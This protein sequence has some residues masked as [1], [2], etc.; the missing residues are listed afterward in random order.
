MNKP[1]TDIMADLETWGTEPGS[2]IAAIG[3]CVVGEPDLTFY[4][5]ITLQSCLDA[6]LRVSGSTVEWWLRQAPEAQAALLVDQ[7]DLESALY[8][9]SAW[10]HDRQ[11][12]RGA[13]LWGN[14]ANFDPV[15]LESAYRAVGQAIPWKFY[16]VACYRTMKGLVSFKA[17]KPTVA[18][19]ALYD[20]LAQAE[21]LV[22]IRRAIS[23]DLNEKANFDAT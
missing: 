11:L 20:A 17:P 8:Q 2:A 10:Y 4:T 1:T 5:T 16:E 19:H 12:G 7:V 22:A 9:F 13:R 23:V 6:G 15:L 14:G 18:H 21:H 3:A